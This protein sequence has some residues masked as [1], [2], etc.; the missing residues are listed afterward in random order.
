M[1]T[2]YQLAWSVALAYQAS[3]PWSR[4]RLTR[5]LAIRSVVKEATCTSKYF[6][7]VAGAIVAGGA[8][9]AVSVEA[10]GDGDSVEVASGEGAGVSDDPDPVVPT[11]AGIT[12]SV[13]AGSV[14]VGSGGRVAVWRM[15]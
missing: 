9:S 4:R 2:R 10:S 3:T 5:T 13:P 6:P 14:S 1:K 12:G 15:T 7:V 8:G 11:S